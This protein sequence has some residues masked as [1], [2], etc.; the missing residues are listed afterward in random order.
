MTVEAL[1]RARQR[2]AHAQ[3][4]PHTHTR[5]VYSH[6]TTHAHN[7]RRHAPRQKADDARL[8]RP[9]AS[10]QASTCIWTP[11][12]EEDTMRQAAIALRHSSNLHSPI[13]VTFCEPKA[14]Q[15]SSIHA[16]I[17]RPRACAVY[18]PI[19]RWRRK[20]STRKTPVP[21]LHT[22]HGPTATLML[23]GANLVFPPVPM[24]APKERSS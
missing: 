21:H 9:R 8:F 12:T 10:I 14:P 18:G 3:R 22:Q 5:S 11:E 19:E 16:T 24:R 4:E 13:S 17:A 1:Q 2:V 7:C 6:P 15:Q 20:L 23:W